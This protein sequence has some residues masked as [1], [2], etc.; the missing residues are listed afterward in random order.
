MSVGSGIIFWI[1]G[2][3]GIPAILVGKESIYVSDLTVDRRTKRETEFGTRFGARINALENTDSTV[4][5][6]EEAKTY[7]RKGA[8][9]LESTLGLGEIRYDTPDP[10]SSNQWHVNYRY[11]PKDFKRG[12]IKGGRKGAEDAKQIILREIA[13]ELG[14]ILGSTEIAKMIVLGD[15]RGYTIFSL[16]I[17]NLS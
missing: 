1:M 2:P 14:L 10:I 16:E 8:R 15:C 9:E 3:D 7:F 13:E 17:N 4:K 6:E 12:I 5:T 11:L